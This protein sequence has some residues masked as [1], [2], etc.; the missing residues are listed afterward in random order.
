MFGRKQRRIEELEA[1]IRAH[2]HYEFPDDQ[3][4]D[5]IERFGQ[6]MQANYDLWSVL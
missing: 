4:Y 6:A 5:C 3:Q 2:E 1:A